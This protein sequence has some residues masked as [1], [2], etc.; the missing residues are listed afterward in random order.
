MTTTVL[1]P[2]RRKFMEYLAER[3]PALTATQIRARVWAAAAELDAALED[4]D[5]RVSLAPMP[6]GEWNI[7]QVVDHVAQTTIRVA[8]ELR[9]LLEGRRPPGPPVYEGLTSGAAHWAPWIDL[10]DGLRAAN[11]EF[12][13]V[14]GRAVGSEPVTAATARTI[15]VVNRTLADGR[16]EPEIFEAELDWK[17]YAIVQR[18]HLLDHRTQVRKLRERQET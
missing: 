8:E 9:H 17:G 7:A 18:F 16:S 15:L 12:D 10:L 6:P 1:S 14:L 2:E 3:A 11:A 13:S 5:E 4:V